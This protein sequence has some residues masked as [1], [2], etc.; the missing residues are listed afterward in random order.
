[1]RGG[2]FS[3]AESAEYAKN[4][5]ERKPGANVHSAFVF[6]GRA[7]DMAVRG[8]RTVEQHAG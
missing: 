7:G 4:K 2:T 6:G 3:V 5:K 8:E 1:V